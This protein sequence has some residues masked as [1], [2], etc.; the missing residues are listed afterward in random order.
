[1]ETSARP[2]KILNLLLTPDVKMA[3]A[4]RIVTQGI[5]HALTQLLGRSA[6]FTLTLM[7]TIVSALASLILVQP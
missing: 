5:Q 4:Y 3:S 1:M 7:P 2:L 6:V